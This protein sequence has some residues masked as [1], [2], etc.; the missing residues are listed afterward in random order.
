MLIQQKQLCRSF[1]RLQ[2]SFEAL[3]DN[4]NRF[5]HMAKKLVFPNFNRCFYEFG[6]I[7]LH[8]HFS[9]SSFPSFLLHK[10]A[11]KLQLT[12]SAD[13]GTVFRICDWTTWVHL[14][15]LCRGYINPLRN[16]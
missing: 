8:L 5:C 9:A 16:F 10:S 12:I 6:Q 4:Y 14:L 15:S 7:I 13:F 11:V 1:D 3:F 2:L